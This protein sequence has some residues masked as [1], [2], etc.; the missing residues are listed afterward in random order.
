VFTEL[1]ILP[2]VYSSLAKEEMF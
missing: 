1:I 2:N